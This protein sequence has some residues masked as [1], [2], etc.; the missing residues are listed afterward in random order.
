MGH[1]TKDVEAPSTSDNLQPILN[2]AAA[3][4]HAAIPGKLGSQKNGEGMEI[5]ITTRESKSVAAELL[6]L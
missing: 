5:E 2:T 6:G 3:P 1:F 4:R